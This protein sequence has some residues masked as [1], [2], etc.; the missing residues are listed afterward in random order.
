MG[1]EGGVEV[2]IPTA[3]VLLNDCAVELSSDCLS[4][5]L[6]ILVRK[7]YFSSKQWL[8]QRVLTSQRAKYEKLNA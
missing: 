7:T 1:L 2:Y 4:V 8:M 6:S 3:L 5:L